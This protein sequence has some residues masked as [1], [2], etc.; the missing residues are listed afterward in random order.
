MGMAMGARPLAF[1]IGSNAGRVV[2]CAGVLL[3]AA[4]VLWLRG[5]L[6]RAEAL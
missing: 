4:G 6:R 1:L 3:D 5:L 2:C